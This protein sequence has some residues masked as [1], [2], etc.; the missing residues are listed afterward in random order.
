MNI[1]S[2]ANRAESLYRVLY[3]AQPSVAIVGRFVPLVIFGAIVTRVRRAVVVR[4]LCG[5]GLASCCLRR[6]QVLEQTAAVRDERV[7]RLLQARTAQVDG[8]RHW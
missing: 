7:E 8:L 3:A 2:L 6:R 5:R 4:S 1:V